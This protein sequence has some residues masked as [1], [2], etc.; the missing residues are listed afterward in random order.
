[1]QERTR[2][3]RAYSPFRFTDQICRV[4]C[5][6]D[7]RVWF[8]DQ[9]SF[10]V[11]N[12]QTDNFSTYNLVPMFRNETARIYS[13][14][15]DAYGQV[16]IGTE[17]GNFVMDSRTGAMREFRLPDP[18]RTGASELSLSPSLATLITEDRTGRIWVG[19]QREIY[20]LK[21]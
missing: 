18:Q 19:S 20:I 6:R 15:V 16:M 10:A 14:Y 4:F 9:G 17:C 2:E 13:I 8:A 11:Y 12:R 1:F 21:Q 7:D 5:T 3:W